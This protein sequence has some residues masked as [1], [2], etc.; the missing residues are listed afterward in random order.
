MRHMIIFTRVVE[1]GSITAAARELGVGKSVVSQHLRALEEAL[2]VLLLKRSTRQQLLTPMGIE[3]FERCKKISELVD[4]AWDMARISQVEPKG[5]VKISS[6]HALIEPVI[7]PAVGHLVSIYSELVPTILANDGSVDLFETAADLAIHVGELPSS[8][9]RQRRIGSLKKVLCASPSYILNHDLSIAKLIKDPSQLLACD[10]VAN[11]WEG[12]SIRYTLQHSSSGE[13]IE[14][15]LEANRFNDSVHS[16]IS[17]V[18]A[19]AGMA[20]IPEFMF[21]SLRRK[22]ELENIFPGYTL[23]K[24]PIYAVHNYAKT[25]PLNVKMCTDFIER[26]LRNLN[27]SEDA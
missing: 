2:G 13:R 8:E 23:P 20:L 18:K 9:Y 6:P 4:E 25:P 26:Q 7:S 17:M 10:Y 12:K 24:I 15:S 3:F 27:S 14:V 21:E 19:G 1:T 5:M 16:V 22:G 11:I